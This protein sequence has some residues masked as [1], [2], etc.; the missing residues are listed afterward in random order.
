VTPFFA[1]HE[2]AI[3]PKQTWAS[4]LQMS[5]LEGKAETSL[6]LLACTQSG[7]GRDVYSAHI[8]DSDGAHL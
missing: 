2:S 6:K 7:E 8:C 3:G 4:A 5:V 1:L